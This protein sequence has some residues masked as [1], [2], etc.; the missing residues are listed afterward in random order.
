MSQS[1]FRQG[2]GNQ[3][4]SIFSAFCKESRS[5]MHLICDAMFLIL[6]YWVYFILIETT[7]KILKFFL[8]FIKKLL[9][10]DKDK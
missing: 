7:L 5:A 10:Y 8:H 4:P 1:Y 6:F 9:R 3:F 2:K